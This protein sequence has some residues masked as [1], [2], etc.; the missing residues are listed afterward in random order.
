ME[1]LRKSYL[2]SRNENDPSLMLDMEREGHEW[3]YGMLG[4]TLFFS[5][6][7]TISLSVVGDEGELSQWSSL[8]D[9]SN[10]IPETT[11]TTISIDRS[12]GTFRYELAYSVTLCPSVFS[13]TRMITFYPRYQIVNLLQAGS[14]YIAQDSALSSETC[15][16]SL[17]SVYYHWEDSSLE[18]KIRLCSASGSWTRGCIQLDKIGVTAMRIPLSSSEKPM[19]VQA[20]VRMA[21]KKEDSAIV[22]TVRASSE[23][24][25]PLYLLKNNSHHTMF[26][27]QK[28]D[29]GDAY[30][31]TVNPGESICYG[32]DDPLLP[33]ELEW[34]W[35]KSWFMSTIEVDAMGSKST[36]TTRDGIQFTSTIQAHRS[37]KVILFSDASMQRSNNLIDDDVDD[38]VDVCVT[39][40]VNG[41]MV[42][43][44]DKSKSKLEQEIILL[45]AESWRARF[46]QRQGFHEIELKLTR[47]KIENFIPGAEFPV[48]VNCP[49]DEDI[50]FFHLLAVRSIQEHNDT[51]V[52]SYCGLRML[53]INI[54]LDRKTAETLAH[55]LHPLRKARDEC[56]DANW[57][58]SLTSKMRLHSNPSRLPRMPN[59]NVNDANTGRIYLEELHLHPI[60]LYLTFTQ[61]RLEW[62]PVTEGLVIFQLIRGMASIADAPLFFTSFVVSNAFESPSILLGIISEH[63]SSQLA[64]QILSI[65][66]SL[67]IF[68]APVD[69][70][71]SFGTGARDYLYEP[72]KYLMNKATGEIMKVIRIK[73]NKLFCPTLSTD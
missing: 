8:I 25:N 12:Y 43:V 7:E 23:K 70:L 30:I 38:T 2:L 41:I 1:T 19:V 27:R 3:T 62:N 64:S 18:P 54:C 66:G 71:S 40:D 44:D 46:S 21:S 59:V 16:P 53:D 33:H 24:S 67:V 57:S 51:T 9:L 42:H 45:T 65:L 4:M 10:I 29:L 31:W 72:V 50:P 20:E 14:L 6:E 11:K 37:T 15:I 32:F 56:H 68:R 55:F 73:P 61:E 69:L 60:Q 28:L 17:S 48:F 58:T 22:V 13:R 39:L 49:N 52:V 26:C 47:L 35:S 5:R 36:I 63:Y 34:N